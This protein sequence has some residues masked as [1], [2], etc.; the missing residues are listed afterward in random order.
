MRFPDAWGHPRQTAVFSVFYCVCM[1][2]R[3]KETEKEKSVVL[4]QLPDQG[5][6]R[7]LK[8]ERFQD[9]PKGYSFHACAYVASFNPHS[10]QLNSYCVPG[11]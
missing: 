10:L 6:S 2:L 11:T 9:F 7:L 4:S 5:S 3:E 8:N 1:C